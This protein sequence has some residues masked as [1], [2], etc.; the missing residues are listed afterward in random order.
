MSEEKQVRGKIEA[1]SRKPDNFYLKIGD[2]WVSGLNKVFSNELNI[3]AKGDI[4]DATY[5]ENV[6]SERTYNNLVKGKLKI[7]KGKP[8]EFKPASDNA[9]AQRDEEKRRDILKSVSIKGA[10][11][12]IGHCMNNAGETDKEKTKRVLDIAD[13]MYAWLKDEKKSINQDVEVK[14]EL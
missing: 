3:L 12:L 8:S 9:Y 10:I 1:I 2:V 7:E 4:A 11:E 13:N 6:T 5:T 14:V